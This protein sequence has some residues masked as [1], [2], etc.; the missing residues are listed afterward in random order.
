MKKAVKIWLIVAASLV[1]LGVLI[2]GGAMMSLNWNF[3][4]LATYKYEIN[5]YSIEGDFK[6]IAVDIETADVELLLSENGERRVVCRES[7]KEKH[8]VTVENG[9]LFISTRNNKKWYDY[10]GIGFKSISLKI[11]LPAGEY[12]SLNVQASTGKLSIAEGFVFEELFVRKSTGDVK[13]SSSTLGSTNIRTSTGDI[14]LEKVSSGSLELIASTGEITLSGVAC[15][16]VI[17][18]KVTTGKV[19][20]TDVRAKSLTSE[21]GTGD[22]TLTGVVCEEKLMIERSTGD[23]MFDGSDAAEISVETDTGNVKGTLLSDKVFLVETETGRVEV[24][25][26]T[27]GGR[28][29]IE[30]ETGNVKISIK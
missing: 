4:N 3:L 18:T 24:P 28:C 11:Y 14:V 13:V 6:D 30:T 7:A 17:N 12:G 1:L 22:I 21:G 19:L 26:S 20:L 8:S 10:I 5:E 9:I 15:E 25:K 16:G 27:V 2:F 23:V 29:E